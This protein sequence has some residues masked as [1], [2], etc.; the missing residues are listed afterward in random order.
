MGHHAYPIGRKVDMSDR[1]GVECVDGES[2]S[3]G[4]WVWINAELVMSRASASSI[5]IRMTPG[6][7]F[8]E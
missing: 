8:V 4:D 5:A 3:N 2:K 7:K 1:H 6:I